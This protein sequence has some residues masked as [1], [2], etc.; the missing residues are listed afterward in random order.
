MGLIHMLKVSGN[1]PGFVSG[2]SKIEAVLAKKGYKLY[3]I[4]KGANG[5]DCRDWRRGKDQI[6]IGGS[7]GVYDIDNRKDG[8]AK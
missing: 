4:A 5:M 8:G 7:D 1:V 2:N 3:G 6:L